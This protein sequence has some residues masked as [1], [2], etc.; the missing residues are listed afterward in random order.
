M[1]RVLLFAIAGA[2]LL[3]GCAEPAT[4]AGPDAGS[5]ADAALMSNAQAQDLVEQ[6]ASALPERYGFR[7]TAVRGGSELMAAEGTFDNV[8]GTHHVS[9]RGSAAVFGGLRAFADGLSVYTSR[10]GAVY[11][12]AGLAV[13]QGAGANEL[14][15]IVPTALFTPEA[16]LDE[17]DADIRVTQ[18]AATAWK[19]QPATEVSFTA[20][21]GNQSI[22]GKMVVLQSPVR[23]V[24]LEGTLPP[25][26]GMMAGAVMAV[27]LL[28][29]DEVPAVP[30]APQRLVRLAYDIEAVGPGT[31]TWTFLAGALPLGE[32][33]VR[34]QDASAG[35]D[36]AEAPAV[37]QLALSDGD[38]SGEGVTL[39]FDD[40]D[41]DGALTAGDTLTIT[42]ASDATVEPRVL[43]HDSVTGKLVTAD[44]AVVMMAMMGGF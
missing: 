34:V 14:E 7:F 39:A 1:Q 5:A 9:V 4:D 22:P 3:A 40:K 33:S 44:F 38:A 19:G 41:G 11:E 35:G 17:L 32:L 30:A 43:L 10:D 31:E 42:T 27:D 21:E 26:A 28:Y 16:V 8:T 20:S 6:A 37:L 24:H 12:L 29:D 15:G 36:M 18:V 2:V 23:L 13:V 25:E